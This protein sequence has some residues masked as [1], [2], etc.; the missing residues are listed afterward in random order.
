M[1]TFK[2]IFAALLLLE[3]VCS[4]ICLFDVHNTEGMIWFLL[5]TFNV[6]SILSFMLIK[7]ASA[8]Q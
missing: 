2:L 3:A 6:S 4:F 8:E 1:K 7:S 5:A